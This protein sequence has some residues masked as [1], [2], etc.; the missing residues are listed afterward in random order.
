MTTPSLV[1]EA[2]VRE[3]LD[4]EQSGSSKYGSDLIGSN[5][6]AASWML[7]RATRRIFRDESNLTLRF[8]TD[9]QARILIPGLRTASTVTQ[10]SS[11]LTVDE[12]YWLI[13]DMQQ[14]GLYTG[15]QVR[16]WAT[17]SG[18]PWYL[19][20]PDWWDR[21]LDSPY[22]TRGGGRP[23]ALPNDL[24]ITGAW[25]YTEATLPEPVRDAT[26]VLAAF[27]TLRPDA[28]LSGARVTET[29]IYDL[30]RFPIEVQSFIADWRLENQAVGI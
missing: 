6:R 15:I 24:V 16:P 28:F 19:S 1:S 26:K 29:G 22:W 21:N 30:S 20:I 7:E 2:A 8:S 12:S 10:N 27:K 23:G 9:G 4:L 13:P 17:N 25:G 14:T 18:G 5:I 11:S 3:L